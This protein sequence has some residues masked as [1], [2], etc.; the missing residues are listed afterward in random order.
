MKITKRQL[1]RIIREEKA[2]LLTEGVY[3]HEILDEA[4]KALSSRDGGKIE[5]LA[6]QVSDL[7]IGEDEKRAFENTL[8]AMA[9]AAYELESFEGG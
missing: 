9:D 2:R 4:G 1:R 8:Y 6:S 3:L 5:S 7:M